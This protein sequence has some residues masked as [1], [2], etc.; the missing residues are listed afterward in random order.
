[1]QLCVAFNGEFYTCM[2]CRY[3]LLELQRPGYHGVTNF[4]V[5]TGEISCGAGGMHDHALK[6]FSNLTAFERVE[7]LL[8]VPAVAQ[9]MPAVKELHSEFAPALEEE[10]EEPLVPPC[11]VTMHLETLE[12]SVSKKQP[13]TE[14]AVAHLAGMLPG[15]LPATKQQP[16]RAPGDYQVVERALHRLHCAAA[17]KASCMWYGYR[18]GAGADKAARSGVRVLQREALGHR[19]AACL[20]YMGAPRLCALRADRCCLPSPFC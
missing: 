7:E 16:V 8:A 11:V 18:C 19:V 13:D 12:D 14:A 5:A 4:A 9:C 17:M 1:M 10:S 15:S 3:D 20:L 6:F 2:C